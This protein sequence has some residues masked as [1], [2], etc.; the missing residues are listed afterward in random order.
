MN[1]SNVRLIFVRELRDQLRDRRT[2]FMVAVL[3]MFLYPVLGVG[4]VHMTLLFSEQPRTVVVLGRAN[5]P[6]EPPLLDEN[7]FVPSWFAMAGQAEQLRV[8]DDQSTLAEAGSQTESAREAR[9]LIRAAQRVET[10][11]FELQKLEQQLRSGLQQSSEDAGQ[12]AANADVAELSKLAEQVAQRRTAIGRLFAKTPVQVLIIFPDGFGEN[13]ERVNRDIRDGK[14][15]QADYERPV[16]VHN[17]ADDKS[18]I[19]YDRIKKAIAAWEEKILVR[20]LE[21][22]DL[23]QTLATP[24]NPASADLAEDEQKA[25][26][27]WSK[28]F[29]ALLIIMAVTGAF[30]PAIDL[31]AGEKERGTMETLLICPASR[32]EIVMGKFL[33]VMVFSMSTAILNLLSMGITGRHMHSLAGGALSKLGDLSLPTAASLLWLVVLLVPLAAFFSALCLALAT[34]ARSIKEGQYYLTPLLMVTLGVTMFCLSPAIEISPESDSSWFYSVMPVMGVA[35]L[36]KAF[37]LSPANPAELYPYAIPVLVTSVGYSLLALWW[38]IEQFSREEILFREADSFDLRLWVRHL[39]R[40]KEPTPSFTEAGFCFIL[41]MLLQFVA[42]K[43]LMNAIGG[44]G[45]GLAMMKLLITQQAVII[46]CPAMLMGIMLTTNVA[47]TFSLSRPRLGMLGLAVVLSCCLHP[48]SL[49]LQHRL[50]WFFPE[51]KPQIVEVIG[52]MSDT[53]Q[54]LWLVLLAFALAPAIC[55]EVAFRGF[56]FSGF[57]RR[58]KLWPAIALSSLAFGII[59]MVP[60]QVFN[61]SL[62]GIVLALILVR[63]GSL[64]CCIAF[65]FVFNALAVMHGRFGSETVISGPLS[66]FVSNRDGQLNYEA[67]T[68]SI[69]ALVASLLLLRLIRWDSV[70][71]DEGQP[72]AALSTLAGVTGETPVRVGSDRS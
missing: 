35:L 36:L 13:I 56:I 54:S 57:R 38:A 42:M 37:L 68:L 31:G 30:Y 29:P 58:H 26:N 50:S 53:D 65:H 7:G 51:L 15:T 19:A 14:Q 2:L 67:P 8:V 71:A 28:L 24:V 9:E 32:R 3:P 60:Q 66:W 39:L 34:F 40:D 6:Q 16:I 11:F 70:A 63:G 23:P 69:A 4:M 49:E 61:A 22:L 20:R 5:L 62:L 43:Y 59:H 33:T 47:K 46:F 48:L 52:A 18:M 27:M 55:E 72:V 12:G 64:F 17:S 45:D 44:S 1:W 10:A 25:A 21:K 41:I